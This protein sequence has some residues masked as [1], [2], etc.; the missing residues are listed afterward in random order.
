MEEEEEG[1]EEAADR[2]GQRT[3]VPPAVRPAGLPHRLPGLPAC[4]SPFPAVEAE[5]A[6]DR[7]EREGV[8]RGGEAPGDRRGGGKERK[9]PVE[10]KLLSRT[11]RPETRAGAN[12]L[13]SRLPIFPLNPVS[14][15]SRPL[16]YAAWGPRRRW[17]APAGEAARRAGGPHRR[18]SAERVG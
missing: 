7:G 10:A 9:P 17:P 11:P 1:A 5:E 4:L 15:F 3:R 16:G 6:D 8:G 12:T 14:L 18:G 13:A 2:R